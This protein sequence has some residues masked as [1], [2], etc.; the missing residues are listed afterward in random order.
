MRA[1]AQNGKDTEARVTG[2]FRAERLSPEA[3]AREKRERLEQQARDLEAVYLQKI[4]DE[5]FPDGEDSGLYG[6]TAATGVYRHMFIEQA[7]KQWAED[8]GGGLSER[9]LRDLTREGDTGQAT[10][11]EARFYALPEGVR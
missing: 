1:A 10:R 6:D 9:L 11:G 8:G 7:A 4:L 3:E 2:R 5:A